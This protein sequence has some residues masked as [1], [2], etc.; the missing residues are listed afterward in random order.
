MTAHLNDNLPDDEA[1]EAALRK[2]LAANG[3]LRA[4]D[5]P[6]GLVARAARRLPGEPPAVIHRRERRMAR[7]RW[8]SRASGIVALAFAGVASGWAALGG[9]PPAVQVSD[10]AGVSDLVAALVPRAGALDGAPAQAASGALV[11]FGLLLLCVLLLARWPGRT[12]VAGFTLAHMPGR[13]LLAGLPLALA[14]AALLGL[15]G[16]LAT[17]PVGLP[18]AGLLLALALAPQVFGLAALARAIGARLTQQP[19]PL[20]EIDWPTLAMAAGLALAPAI[21]AALAPG[22]APALL[23]ALSAPGLGAAA[24]SRAGTYVPET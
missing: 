5:A 8:I 23:G 10:R 24:L 3:A 18:L 4:L 14:L 21:T 22:W 7:A 2:A 16:L 9:E 6:P 13:A 12:A 17:T 19:N 20:R 1:A 11:G 15:A